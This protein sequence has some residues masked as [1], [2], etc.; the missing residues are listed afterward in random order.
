MAMIAAIAPADGAT[1]RAEALRIRLE[2]GELILEDHFRFIEQAAD[3][4]ALAVIDAAAGDEAQEALLLEALEI[5]LEAHGLA[6]RTR[7]HQK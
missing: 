7:R 1:L 5:L 4:R 3:Q 2:G 6:I